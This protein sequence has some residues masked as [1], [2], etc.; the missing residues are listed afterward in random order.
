M[1]GLLAQ[2]LGESP[3]EQKARLDEATRNAN[4][5]SGLVRHKKKPKPEASNGTSAGATVSTA[6]GKRK[7]DE[8]DEAGTEGKKTKFES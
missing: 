1:A 7:L 3:A 2:A 6:N 4:D 8:V 5:L